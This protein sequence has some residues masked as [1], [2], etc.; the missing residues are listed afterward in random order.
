MFDQISGNTRDEFNFNYKRK[1]K[2]LCLVEFCQRPK[3]L[4]DIVAL[5]ENVIN[6]VFLTRFFK[7][8]QQSI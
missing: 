6:T 1:R 7:I 4:P 2:R 8:R 3:I 5:V